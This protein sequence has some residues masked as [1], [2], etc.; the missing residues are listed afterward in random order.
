MKLSTSIQ[1]SWQPINRVAELPGIKGAYEIVL[2]Q[3]YLYAH[4]IKLLA[5]VIR[6]S[7]E[8]R[9]KHNFL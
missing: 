9:V 5:Q 2:K 6:G 7:L 4:P 8:K 1:E 3:Q